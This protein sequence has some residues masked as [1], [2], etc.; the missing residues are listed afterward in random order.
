MLFLFL[1]NFDYSFDLTTKQIFLVLKD[2]TLICFIISYDGHKIS[3]LIA[4]C[5]NIDTFAPSSI[6]G[7]T[8]DKTAF[9][10]NGPTA[11]K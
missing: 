6:N 8:P 5:F 10:H 11:F 3:S 7:T 2:F 9:K 1:I 4:N